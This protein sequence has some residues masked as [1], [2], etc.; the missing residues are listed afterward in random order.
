VRRAGTP[1]RRAPSQARS[2]EIWPPTLV[3]GCA[4]WLDLLDGYTES[5]GL[6]TAIPNKVSGEQWEE[7]TNPPRLTTINGRPAI[8]GNGSSQ[9]IISSEAAVASVFSGADKSWTVMLVTQPTAGGSN[10]V[11]FSA[12]NSGFSG[13]RVNYLI[14]LNSNRFQLGKIDD[15]GSFVSQN[16]SAAVDFA[17][18]VVTFISHWTTCSAYVN[19]Q[20]PADPNAASLNN[21]DTTVDQC[22][23]LCRAY[24]TP[25]V[26]SVDPLGA[27][28]VFNRAITSAEHLGLVAGLR[29]EFGL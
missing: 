4:A 16:R 27:V 18:Q 24:G 10:S 1:T 25:D 6:V 15:A 11:L 26:F 29:R 19:T 8:D 2:Y 23:L 9:R 5:S 12:G 21:G 3:E 17:P 22:G 7:P 28:L 14:R 13:S 20:E